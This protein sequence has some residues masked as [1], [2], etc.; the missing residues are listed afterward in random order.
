MIKYTNEAAFSNQIF[1]TPFENSLDLKNRWVLLAEVIPWDKMSVIFMQGMSNNIGRATVDLRTIMGA[2]FIQHSLNLTDRSTIEMISENI[3]MQ[4][5]VG[6][7][8]FQLTPVFD[9]LK[10][11]RLGDNIGSLS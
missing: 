3:Y 11:L 6:L 1:K 2:M 7:S 9:Q 5:F 10:W 4:Y 8:S